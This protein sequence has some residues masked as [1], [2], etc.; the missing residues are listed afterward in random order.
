MIIDKLCYQ[1]GLRYV[2]ANLKFIFAMTSLLCCVVSRSVPAAMAVLVTNAVL[3]IKIGGISFVK[4]RKLMGVP[5]AFLLLSTFTIIVNISGEPMDGYAFQIGNLYLTG[6]RASLVF[7]AK[8]IITALAAVSSLYFLTLNTTMTDILGV[9]EWLHVPALV[10]ELMMLIYRFIFVLTEVASNI[11]VSQYSRLGNRD[12]RASLRS[13][14][15][16]AAAVFVRAVK[17]S[18]FLYVAMESSCY[19][20]KVRVLRE[21]YPAKRW[22]IGLVAGYE[23]L[24]IGIVIVEK[25]L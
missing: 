23:C 14:G 8:L 7:G 1:S 25:C 2:N 19:D 12:F 13:F 24:L 10:T 6:S 5:L 16:M 17:K 20:G 18:S 15:Q 11:T 21:Q 4:Y 9:M 3:T 22:Q